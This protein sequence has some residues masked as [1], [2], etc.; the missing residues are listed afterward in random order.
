MPAVLSLL[1]H[2]SSV[3]TD[4]ISQIL[5]RSLGVILV[6][7]P[8]QLH[9][10]ITKENEKAKGGNDVRRDLKVLDLDTKIKKHAR[11]WYINHVYVDTLRISKWQLCPAYM[12]VDLFML[13]QI[14]VAFFH[15]S[16]VFWANVLKCLFYVNF[17]LD[18]ISK[19]Q[20]GLFSI[21]S[22]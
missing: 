9:L 10:L 6:I 18:R 20:T 12:K 7:I 4:K 14:S 1:Q 15:L 13:M 17:F 19:T 5:L 22:A 8:I 11:F 2:F 3:V 16:V 21:K